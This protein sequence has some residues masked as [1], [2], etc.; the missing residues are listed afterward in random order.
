MIIVK[1][2]VDLSTIRIIIKSI[3]I[4]LYITKPDFTDKV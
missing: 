4:P 1:Y 2:W 3:L